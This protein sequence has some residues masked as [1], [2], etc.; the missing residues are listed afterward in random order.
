MIRCDECGKKALVFA[1]RRKRSGKAARAGIP[2]CL[3]HH[4]LCPRCWK[5]QRDRMRH[6]PERTVPMSQD[7]FDEISRFDGDFKPEMSFRPGAK[8]LPDG[9][10]DLEIVEARPD[11]TQDSRD[12]ILRVSLRVLSGPVSG[13]VIDHVYFLTKLESCERLGGD[14]CALGLDADQWKPPQRP[15]SRELG[16]ALPKLAG[17]RF[18]AMKETNTTQQGKTFHNI[19]INSL[20]PKG[21]TLLPA[22]VVVGAPSVAQQQAQA[23]ATTQQERSLFRTQNGQNGGGVTQAGA[24]AIAAREEGHESIPF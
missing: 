4:S 21:A 8:L 7:V 15:F 16:L 17:R 18:R 24:A 11:R 6:Q 20:L 5:V 12:A 13:T 1:R 22:G 19:R 10:V 23:A 2:R 14:L 3:K 9:L